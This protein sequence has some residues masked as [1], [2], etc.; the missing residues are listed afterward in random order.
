[1]NE[2]NLGAKVVQD[3]TQS[4]YERVF[5]HKFPKKNGCTSWRYTV[6]LPSKPLSST[7]GLT[8]CKQNPQRLL[9]GI[10]DR[11]FVDCGSLAD[12]NKT[13]KRSM[14]NYN[15]ILSVDRFYFC[16]EDGD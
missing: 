11:A 8:F 6:I 9:K 2:M 3:P 14:Q 13:Q 12:S 15:R 10:A 16:V 4:K 5:R 1:M 7:R